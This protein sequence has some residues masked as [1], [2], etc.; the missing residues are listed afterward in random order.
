MT[1]LTPEQL[2]IIEHAATSRNH[3]V[4][5]AKAGSGKT[6]TLLELL[7]KLKGSVSF[8]AFNKA[9]ATEVQAKATNKYGMMASMNWNISTV[10]ALGLSIFRKAGQKPQ[11]SGGKTSFMLKDLIKED[12]PKD[13]DP[14]HLNTTHI[15]N[16]VGYAKAAGF[17][18]TSPAEHFPGLMDT[19]A[20]YALGEHYDLWDDLQG[21]MSPEAAI[22]WAKDLLLRSNKRLSMVDFDDM[23]YLPLLHNMTPPTFQNVLIDE[24]QDINATRRELAFRVLAPGGKLIAVGDPNQAIYGFTGAAADS[25]PRIKDR[26]QADV[27][28][29]TICWRCDSE[30]IAAAQR[31]VPTIRARPGAPAG[32]VSNVNFISEDGPDFLDM[33]VAGDA[34]LCRLNRPNVAAALGLIRRGMKARIEGRD[35]GQR[36]LGHVKSCNDAYAFAKMHELLSDLEYHSAQE[37]ARLLQ[38]KRESAAALLV[39]ECDAASLLIERSIEQHGPNATWAQLEAL[40]QTLFGDDVS[41]KD[42]VTLSSVHKA[43]GREWPRVFILGYSDYM[44]FFAASMDW[45]LEQEDNLRYVAIT[46]AERE[47]ILVHGVQS[48]LDKGLHRQAPKSA[49]ATTKIADETKL[50]GANMTGANLIG[51]NMADANLV[52]A[53]VGY[54]KKGLR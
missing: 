21:G 53:R 27:L 24:A 25:L 3:L 51:A 30:I 17:G 5:D 33:P 40:F 47:L 20:W 49:A 22:E 29:L 2:A 16:L 41:A 11:V 6:S 12:R 43:K 46:R 1:N 31:F 44:P 39:D 8:Q 19:D 23:I 13:D 10:H 45:E 38:K 37:E 34:I 26:A 7:P 9:I 28:P 54:F 35:I 18:L 15:R 42:V 4:V 50:D 14:I 52:G 32:K 48:A 36:L